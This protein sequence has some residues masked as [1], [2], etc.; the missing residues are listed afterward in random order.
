MKGNVDK[1][2]YFQVKMSEEIALE[3]DKLQ[4][5]MVAG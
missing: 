3:D 5:L 4:I 2:R 1:Q